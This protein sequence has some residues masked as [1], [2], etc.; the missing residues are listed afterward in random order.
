M[1]RLWS[2]ALVAGIASVIAVAIATAHEDHSTDEWP[3]TCV[4]LNDVVETHLGNV[5][6]VGIYQRTFGDQAEAAC[7]NDHRNDVRGVFAWAFDDAVQT[8]QSELP[9]LAWPTTCVELNDI[10]EG[11]VGNFG[12]VGIYQRVFDDQAE[13]ACR[14]D[15]REDVRAVFAWA[16]GETPVGRWLA[17]ST[18]ERHTCGIRTNGTVACWGSNTTQYGATYTGQADPPTGT[19]TSVSAGPVHSCGV[20]TDGTIT[21]WGSDYLDRLN[22]PAGTFKSVSAESS[23][24]CA[25][26]TGGTV[27]CWGNDRDG[28]AT[29]PPGEFSSVS[30]GSRFTCGV[31]TDGTIAC[32]GYEGYQGRL[33]SPP[34]GTFTSVSTALS[35]ACAVRTDGSMTCW[36]NLLGASV[37]PGAFE[38]ISIGDFHTCGVRT[39]G[40]VFCRGLDV[41][42]QSTPPPGAFA[43][44]SVGDDHTCGLRVNG[45]IAC[46]GYDD[47]RTTPPPGVFTSLIAGD[48]RACGVRPGG[49][50]RV[51]GMGSG[52]RAVFSIWRIRFGQPGRL[53]CL[54]S[55]SRRDCG[56]LGI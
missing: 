22:A 17:V 25:V 34:S 29:P 47:G 33:A 35:H 53:P 39:D 4:D 27:A 48:K 36:G 56:L 7:Q 1:R 32:W 8:T 18:G 15:H 55:S 38:S 6:N 24:A 13:R 40:T 12:N 16:I 46:W 52:R 37:L 50:G 21:C 20:R 28:Q 42:G 51:L 30:T 2:A 49:R 43:S 41:S 14:N 10:V 26:R 23:H 11:H 45:Q 5:G 9:D 3:M 54:W 19:F 31:R 44:V